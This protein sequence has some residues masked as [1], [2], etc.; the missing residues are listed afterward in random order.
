MHASSSLQAVKRS[1]K[2]T[3]MDWNFSHLHWFL[4]CTMWQCAFVWKKCAPL[5][6]PVNFNLI[7]MFTIESY[8]VHIY[9]Y[10]C[11]LWYFPHFLRQSQ[12][13]FFAA[14]QGAQHLWL[15]GFDWSCGGARD[16]HLLV[17]GQTAA[18]HRCARNVWWHLQCTKFAMEMLGRNWCFFLE[19][20]V[21]LLYHDF[22]CNPRWQWTTE[23]LFVSR[24]FMYIYIE[25]ELSMTWCIGGLRTCGLIF[26]TLMA[27]RKIW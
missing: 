3:R 13:R 14:T 10:T 8:T 23:P 9:I 17:Y 6:S 5:N 15:F 25:N 22:F 4:T 19:V 27:T 21:M 16:V 11:F 18:A 24:W 26:L 1:R 20:E 12:G 2:G 7:I